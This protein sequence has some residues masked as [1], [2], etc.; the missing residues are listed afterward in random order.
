[1]GQLVA[2]TEKLEQE[3]GKVIL[4]QKDVVRQVLV[5]FLSNGHL[6]L[7]GVPG[8]AKTLLAKT[9]AAAI[10]GVF[11][12]IQ[13]TPDLMPSD[14]VG[15]NV[16]NPESRTF[17]FVKGP[18]FCDV[19]LADEINRTPPKTQSALLEVMEER[20]ITIDG[21][22]HVFPNHFFVIATQ[23]PIEYEGTYPLPE[24][25][26]DR[27]MMKIVIS[28]PAAGEEME[29]YESY[30]LDPQFAHSRQGSITAVFPVASV[31][32]VRGETQKIR[33]EKPV[34]EYLQAI[35][36]RT[37]ESPQL[38]LGCSPR[39]GIALLLCSKTLAAMRGR[40]FVIPDDIKENAWPVL[41]HRLIL[42]P[43]AQVEGINAEQIIDSILQGV[44]VPR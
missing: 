2:L 35:V 26:V 7:E 32:T 42:K 38:L 4:G 24:A 29:L 28:Y 14:I 40:D 31:S 9:L 18:I 16:F 13:F 21:T 41:R 5:C 30:S 12:R 15:T 37:R 8:L 22:R 39:A 6:L 10:G 11:H 36:Q 25:Q 33:I 1:M 27:F 3:I 20:Q 17:L 34:L 43:E 23:N 44:K 19:L